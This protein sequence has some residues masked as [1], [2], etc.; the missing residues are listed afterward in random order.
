MGVS[1]RLDAMRK[2]SDATS[3]DGRRHK[4]VLVASPG[5]P[6]FELSIPA[7][8]FGVDRRD[9]TPD[10]YDFELVSTDEA[11][12]TVAHGLTVPSAGG[13]SRLRTADTVIVPACADVQGSAPAALVEELR[14]AH[15]RGARIAATCTGSFVLAEAGL[16][17]GRRAA[18]HWMH[19]DVLAAR[20]PTVRV[21]AEVLYVHDD[22][23]TSAGSAAGLDMCLELVRQD[24]GSAVANELARRIV[25]PPHRDGGQ[26]QFIRPSTRRPAV[27]PDVQ[28]WAR[29]HLADATVVAMAHHAGVSP[30]TLNRQFRSRTGQSP[31]AWLQGLRLDTAAELLETTDLGVE[32][33][34]RQVG[35][36]T[37]T[38]LRTQFAGV[39]GVPP[40]AYRSAFGAPGPVAV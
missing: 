34:A 31:Q 25:V 35:L 15:D 11:G 8:V 21:D 6:L 1:G 16:L 20:H 33:I 29:A 26:A 5:I 22:V 3:R 19:A 9:V 23:W 13:L 27:R 36:G 2:K 14:R 7:E 4:V 38:N 40:T 24:H 32:A 10:W 28:A 17:D 30:R 12:T 39:Y 37:A 18:T